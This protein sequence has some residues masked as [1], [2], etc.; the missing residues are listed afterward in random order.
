MLSTGY[1]YINKGDEIENK[2]FADFHLF[3]TLGSFSFAYRLRPQYEYTPPHGEE[4]AT[5]DYQ[6]RNKFWIKYDSLGKFTPYIACEIRYQLGGN[7]RAELNSKFHRARWEVG[8]HYSFNCKHSLSLFGLMQH[9][10]NL[11]VE[12]QKVFY[13]I[14]L[15]YFYKFAWKMCQDE[16]IKYDAAD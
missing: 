13:V 1:R 15:T 4:I 14:G 3:G 11:P 8:A 5:D 9:E 12:E 6:A 16:H 10:W 7:L 2:Y